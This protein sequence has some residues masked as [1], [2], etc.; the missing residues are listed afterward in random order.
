MPC[1]SRVVV[2]YT[3]IKTARVG[4]GVY[5]FDRDRHPQRLT[6]N[7]WPTFQTNGSK[8]SRRSQYFI[9]PGSIFQP[10]TNKESTRAIDQKAR[11]NFSRIVLANWPLCSFARSPAREAKTQTKAKPWWR[12]ES[13]MVRTCIPPTAC[14]IHRG[15]CR[16]CRSFKNAARS[17]SLE[18][19]HWVK[20]ST[21]PAAGKSSWPTSS[22]RMS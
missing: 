14:G 5:I 22:S 13:Q 8:R 12:R 6:F 1:P 19:K 7:C 2:L 20:A 21:D 15:H 18:L 11:G 10:S 17:D 9:P 3:D 4:V 16:E